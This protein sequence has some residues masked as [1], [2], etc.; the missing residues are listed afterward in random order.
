VLFVSLLGLWRLRPAT[1]PATAP[2]A[3]VQADTAAVWSDRTEGNRERIVLERGALWIHVDHSSGQGPL[4]VELPDGD[5]EDIG[6]T[7]AVS[8]EG[9]H[10]T[11][12]AVQEG[13]VVLRLRGRSPLI[14]GPG[15]TWVPDVPAPAAC[16]SASARSVPFSP[17]SSGTGWPASTMG[18]CRVGR[19]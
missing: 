11:R 10:T 4:V 2:I 1:L 15:D 19:P 18:I 14:V 7:F 6:T 5:L 9:G 8:A 12:V 17:A 13:R 3:V 16:A